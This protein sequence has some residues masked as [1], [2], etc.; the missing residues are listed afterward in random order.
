M[1]LALIAAIALTQEAPEMRLMRQPTIHGDQVVFTYA[2]DLWTTQIGSGTAIRLTT[3]EGMENNARFSPDGKLIAF[4]GQFDNGTDI[5]VISAQGGDP[6][7]VTFEP[8]GESVRGWTPDGMIAY[9][10]SQGSTFTPKLWL[11]SP[12]GGFP[13]STGLVEVSDLSFSPDGKQIAYNRSAA[14]AFNWRGYRGGTQGVISF[15][16]FETRAYRELPHE[17]EN[18]WFPM[19]VGD[20]VL[21]ASDKDT[22]VNLWRHD[23]RTNRTTQLTRF[24]DGDVRWPTTDGRKIVYERNGFLE[25]YHL[26]TG[27]VQPIRLRALGDLTHMRP[28]FRRFG[29]DFDGFSLSPSGRR[30]VVAARGDVFSLPAQHGETRNMTQSSRSRER[31]P[32]WSPCGKFI[33]YRSDASGEW[34]IWIEPQMG[35]EPRRVLTDPN[36]RVE[37]FRWSPDG[38]WLSFTTN[39]QEL[40]IV[41]HLTGRSTLVHRDRRGIGSYDWSPDSRWIAFIGT[42][43]TLL[44]RVMLYELEGNRIHSVTDGAY[45]DDEVSFDLN[46]RYLYFTSMR[47]FRPSP[48]ALE[49]VVGFQNGFRVYVLPLSAT[50]T[51][52]FLPPS[53]EEP[54]GETPPA[55]AAPAGPPAAGP[56]QVNIDLEGLADRA[57]P[58]PWPAGNPATIVGANNGVFVLLNNVLQRFDFGSRQTATIMSGVGDFR[59]NPARTKFAYLSGDRLGIADVRPGLEPGVGVVRLDAVAAT[60]NPRDEF[61]QMYWEVWRYMRDRFYDVDMVGVDWQRAGDKY[62]KMLPHVASRSDLNYLFGLLIGELG[63]GHAY[64]F[65]GEARGVPSAPIGMLG[66][67]FELSGDSIR[68]RTIFRGNNYSEATRGPLGAPGVNIQEGEYLLEI[69]G[70]SVGAQ[71]SPSELLVDRVG[72]SVVLTVNSTPTLEG[73]RRVTVRPIGSEGQLRYESWVES[74]RALV[75]RLSGG[76]IGYMHVPNTSIDGVVGFIKGFY[77]TSDKEAWIIDERYNGG[78]MIPTFFIELL[79]RRTMSAVAARQTEPAG[80]PHSLEGP[81]A[82]LINQYAGSGGDLLPWFFRRAGLGPLIGTRTWGGLV[83]ISG[84]VDLIDGGGV[85]APAFGLFDHVE[86]EWIAENVGVEPDIKVDDRPDYVA[87]GRDRPIEVAVEHLLRELDRGQGRQPIVVP[88]FPRV[89]TSRG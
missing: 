30:V 71:R 83:G 57:L 4:T 51:D 79:S 42:A 85:T 86:Q 64:V 36:L 89:Q 32:A 80:V 31:D 8:G 59:F 74:R 72:R 19:W 28:T 7:R 68:F 14:H 20:S 23:L 56:P 58:L 12:Q 34:Q 38:K 10:S 50:A 11:V 82:M 47:T 2:G 44:S 67:D 88:P 27:E 49:F 60:V 65:G 69:D 78:G 84:S 73:A 48:S 75:D 37:S 18:S 53:D 43:P 24:R 6:R 16:N 15:W 52:P 62:A 13:R 54:A 29:A 17:Q 87:Q 26:T 55:P 9:T 1:D 81:K 40:F 22:N 45:I 25:T 5:Y 21:F 3:H 76:R 46:G 63:T 61:V 33:A 66:A 70:Q 39:N 77:A 41:D 35:G